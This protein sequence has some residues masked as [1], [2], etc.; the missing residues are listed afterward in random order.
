[1]NLKKLLQTVSG[2]S[3]N[4]CSEV[5]AGPYPG[6]EPETNSL[7]NFIMSKSPRWLSHISLHS[8]GAIWLA[9]F[10]YSKIQIPDDFEESVIV[11]LDLENF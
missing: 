5:Y 7:M 2:A 6:S 1:M 11:H 10:S 4:P 9:P 3:A 8:Y